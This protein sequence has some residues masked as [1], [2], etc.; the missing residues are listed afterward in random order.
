MKSSPQPPP[1]PVTP[2]SRRPCRQSS[3]QTRS[4]R[5]LSGQSSRKPIPGSTG[6]NAPE[7][8]S[9]IPNL[10]EAG[11]G[12]AGAIP[13]WKRA[14]DIALVLLILPF[15]A[16]VAS[17]VFLWIQAVSPGSVLFRQTRIGRNG[18]PFTIYKFRSMKLRAPTNVHEA[19]VEHLIKSNLPMT[20]LDAVGDSRLIK[21][22]CLIRTSGL[23]EL[24]QFINVLRGEM[25]LVG[26][27]PCLPKEFELYEEHQRHR[28]SVQPGLTGLWQVNRSASATFTEMVRMDSQ[29]AD[30]LSPMQD[31]KIIVKTPFTLLAQV[32][33]CSQALAKNRVLAPARRSVSP[34]RPPITVS[35]PAFGLSMSATQKLSD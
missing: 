18:K 22:G 6:A 10:Q 19:H 14:S 26:P 13:L 33:E 28:F 16:L 4:R 35:R 32:K 24:P 20:K 21:G 7:F 17:F 11:S 2:T 31:L 8:K 23:D 25:S 27:R 1:T 9:T 12:S 29:Y 5:I 3:P 34:A 15:V 30:Q